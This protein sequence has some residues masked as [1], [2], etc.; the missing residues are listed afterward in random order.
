MMDRMDK[1]AAM[2]DRMRALI[3][4]RVTLIS[5]HLLYVVWRMAD[6]PRSWVSGGDVGV[7]PVDPAS[8][9]TADSC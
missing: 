5:S 4:A 2:R 8:Q 7:V 3:I 9:F 1:E 6:S